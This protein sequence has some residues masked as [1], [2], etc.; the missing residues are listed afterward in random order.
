MDTVA[1]EPEQAPKV[2]GPPLLGARD[3]NGSNLCVEFFH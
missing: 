3:G 2:A 1:L